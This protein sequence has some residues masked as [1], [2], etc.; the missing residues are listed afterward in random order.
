MKRR[1]IIISIAF[2]ILVG[3]SI[4]VI[5][6]VNRSPRLQ[7]AVYR[8][9]NTTAPSNQAVNATTNTNQPTGTPDRQTI[10][11]VSRNFS[12]R[13]GSGSNQNGG[14]NLTEAQAYGTANYN[15]YLASQVAKAKTA[16]PASEYHGTVTRALVFNIIKQTP[17][18]ATV[19]VSTQQTIISGASSIFKP[20]DL[21]V[22][23]VKIVGS[24]KVNAAVWK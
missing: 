4:I 19:L 11:F 23:L 3:A 18:V 7:N 21:L 12:E 2:V 16:P 8:V 5:F 17:T 15:V 22:D 13:Y 20:A 9:T 10:V 24:W 1:L 14:S 6:A